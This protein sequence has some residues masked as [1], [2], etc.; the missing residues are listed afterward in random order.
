M[1]PDAPQCPPTISE[2]PSVGDAL[3]PA[4]GR[5]ITLDVGL[6]TQPRDRFAD[7]SVGSDY[8][9]T[10]IRDDSLRQL[11]LVR[12]ELGFRYIRFHAIF[13]DVLGTY[14][15]VNGQPV[16]D[17]TKLDY[18]Y[19]EL[20]ETGIK[21]FVELGFTPDAMKSSNLTIFYWNGNTSHPDPVKWEGLVD[22]FARHLIDRYG[23]EE[24]R[25]WFFE[26]WNEPNLDAFWE[27]A[28]QAAYFDLYART[29][30]VLKAVDREL[31]VGGP[32]TAGAAWV[33]E[34]L[35]FASAQQV[36]V[37]F[38][39]T[40]A[41]GVDAGFLDE[42]G[43][44]DTK[45]SPSPDA[46][47]GDVRRVREQI[48]ASS[49]PGLPLYFTEWSASYTPRDPVH[50]SY[51]MA[52][53]IL[54][55]LQASKGLAQGMSYW[56][57]TDLFEEPG[58]PSAPFQGGF[59]LL[60]PQGIRKPAYF[61][62]KY[63]NR[64]G[65]RELQTRDGQSIG[66]FDGGTLQVLAW[67]YSA[68]EQSVSNRP[69]FTMVHPVTDTQPLQ[70]ALSGLQPGTYEARTFRTGFERNDAYT[71]YLRLGLP[72]QLTP[73]QVADLQALTLDEPE[74]QTVQI[75]AGGSGLLTVPMRQYDVVLVE[76]QAC[77]P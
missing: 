51:H 29:A 15:E 38:V 32:S 56:A 26:V 74:V 9:G 43:Q 67:D 28:D 70:I 52:S 31:R 1:Q 77:H 35:S 11:K 20:L 64:L 42:L 8:P 75:G 73:Q 10:L 76:L 55:K 58:P 12:D 2:L 33:P 17:W 46:I 14:R 44:S 4:E 54:N 69:F 34:L 57:Y 19:D 68:P 16:Y 48:E 47:I 41:Y 27:G 53:Y 25:S 24:V 37:D 63:L 50:D 40:H 66:A 6:P 30:R 49:S 59:G 45:L 71:A 13:H 21:P 65:D 62:Y 72:P 7:L 3:Q 5:P 18:L 39:T 61:A 60:N 36:A 22:A 23:L